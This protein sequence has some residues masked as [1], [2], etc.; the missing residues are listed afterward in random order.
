MKFS[1][2]DLTISPYQYRITPP[3]TKPNPQLLTDIGEQGMRDLLDRVY[4]ELFD[5]S[6]NDIFPKNRE[7]MI[8]A[9]DNTADFF[10]QICGGDDYFRQKNGSPQMVGRHTFFNITPKARLV[11]LEIFRESIEPIITENLSSEENIKSL[12]NYIDIFSM[13]MVNSKD[14]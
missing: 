14:C 6:I 12:W 4:M 10:I 3:V 5:S 7:D 1:T 9:G 2:L 11:W 13:W 8:K